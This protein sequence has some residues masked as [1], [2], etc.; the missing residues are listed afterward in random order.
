MDVR[1][2][3]GTEPRRAPSNSIDVKMGIIFEFIT[4]RGKRGARGG[5]ETGHE[6]GRAG[7]DPRNAGLHK[8]FFGAES[9]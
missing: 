1:R 7:A 6:T 2:P 4:Q 9:V 8:V 5:N 3:K